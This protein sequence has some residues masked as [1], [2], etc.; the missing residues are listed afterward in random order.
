[1]LR[2]A[3]FSGVLSSASCL[4]LGLCAFVCSQRLGGPGTEVD[5]R[6]MSESLASV[7]LLGPI[8]SGFPILTVVRGHWQVW[9]LDILGVPPMTVLSL[10]R[11]AFVFTLLTSLL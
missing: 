1:M 8:S 9:F 4:F 7:W 6:Q 3:A 11:V 2:T 10:T 5:L